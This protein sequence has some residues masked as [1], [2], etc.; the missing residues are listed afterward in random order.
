MFADRMLATSRYLLADAGSLEIEFH[1]AL[2]LQTYVL[3]IFYVGL[4]IRAAGESI[5]VRMGR[6]W[7]FTIPCGREGEGRSSHGT[8]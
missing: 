5:T 4:K 2:V 7:L 3:N 6:F 8:D 1:V